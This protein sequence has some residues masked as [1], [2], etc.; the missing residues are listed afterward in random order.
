MMALLWWGAALGQFPGQ[1]QKPEPTTPAARDFHDSRYK[2]S[3]HIPAAWNFTQKDGEV[4]TFHL[5][6]RSAG[7]KAQ[8]RAVATIAFNPYP[9]TNFSGALFYFSVR[10]HATEAECMTEASGPKQAKVD[11]IVLDGVSF[12]H[13]HDESGGHVCVEQRDEVYTAERKGACYRF[14][15]AMNSFCSDMSGAREMTEAERANVRGRMETILK[16]VRF[17]KR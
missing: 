7:S 13:G 2:V 11:E 14:D 4:S 8:L 16:S 15:L 9:L 6:A 17:D 12:A 5:D 1:A 3:F 10:P